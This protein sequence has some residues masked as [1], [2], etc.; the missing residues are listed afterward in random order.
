VL[1]NINYFDMKQM[2][3]AQSLENS[4]L[5]KREMHMEDK[6]FNLANNSETYIS[7]DQ[8][9]ESKTI[10]EAIDFSDYPTSTFV[11]TG[12]TAGRESTG[13]TEGH[14]DYGIIYSEV[15][16]NLDLY[17]T[18]AAD[19]DTLPIGTILDTPHYGYGVVAD[20]GGA[21]TANKIAL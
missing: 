16:V 4:E 10:E 12:Y 18:I 19:L 5:E 21:I 2:V 15:E 14:S 17:S 1:T 3:S 20:I 9:D 6:Y 11:A 7:S 13:N 8:I